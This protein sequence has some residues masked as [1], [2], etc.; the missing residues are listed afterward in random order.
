MHRDIP[1]GGVLKAVIRG[2]Q[3]GVPGPREGQQVSHHRRGA[4]TA[5][6]SSPL[7]HC[8]PLRLWLL[9]APFWSIKHGGFV[10]LHLEHKRRELRWFDMGGG[11][12]QA[13]SELADSSHGH[14][15]VRNFQQFSVL[16]AVGQFVLPIH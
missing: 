4:L 7:A 16:P 3:E 2:G 11:I 14:Q 12:N 9:S 10:S 5:G 6:K 13:I 8:A 15:S 1:P